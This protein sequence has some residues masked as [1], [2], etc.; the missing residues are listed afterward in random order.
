MDRNVWNQRY[1]TTDLVWTA[2]PNRFLVAE[3]EGLAPGT[4]LDLG[5]GEGRN[6]V[7]LA[8][9][10]WQVTG[11]D[12]SDVGLAKAD[13]LAAAAGVDVSTTCADV[14][15]Y[16]PPPR[17]FD[18]VAVVYV[19]LPASVRRAVYRR[20]ADGVAP[21]GT[22]LVVGHDTTNPTDGYGGPQNPDVLFSPDD[23]VVADLAGSGLVVEK[24]ERVPRPVMTEDGPRVAIDA[25]VRAWRPEEP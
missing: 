25:L 23:D 2:E 4:A 16:T 12:F 1:E 18:L 24:A 17:G 21:G 14:T 13:Q 7:W 5:A 8:Q 10:G 6:A 22:L 19:H 11:V 20:A 9:Q 3:V 15:G